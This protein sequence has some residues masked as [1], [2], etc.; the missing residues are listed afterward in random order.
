MK[1]IASIIFLTL[2][3]SLNFGCKKDDKQDGLIT[4]SGI[5]E[6][7]LY[8][9]STGKVDQTDWRFDDIWPQFVENLFNQDNPELLLPTE[10]SPL[11]ILALV[12]CYPNP[13]KGGE[14]M[15][16]SFPSM[17]SDIRIVDSNLNIYYKHDYQENSRI[18]FNDSFFKNNQLFRV[19][20]KLYY[21]SK[22]YRGHGDFKF[23]K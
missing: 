2:F 1:A 16:L 7:D 21:E 18:K 22:V 10:Q 6:R 23:I 9:N 5:T 11:P 17:Y 8:A 19:Y 4:I 13:A 20:Y 12:S 15:N 3:L 14:I